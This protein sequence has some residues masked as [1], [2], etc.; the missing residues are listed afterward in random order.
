[1]YNI[2]RV[3]KT[4]WD[5]VVNLMDDEKREQVH[6]E[7]APCTNEEFLD[8]YLEIDS[9]FENILNSEF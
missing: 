2:E 1:M 5:I 8:R 3:L 9:D 7:L 4:H 6:R